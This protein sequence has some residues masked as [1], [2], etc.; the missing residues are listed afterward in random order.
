MGTDRKIFWAAGAAVLVLLVLLLLSGKVERELAPRP[1][2]AWV[3]IEVG[4]GELAEVGRVEIESG[5]PFTLHAVLEATSWRGETLYFTQAER[6]R[7]HGEEVPAESLRPWKSSAEIRIL[8]FTVEGFAPYLDVRRPEDFKRFR[9]R[10]SF[11]SEWP[12]AWSIPGHLEPSSESL[13]PRPMETGFPPFGTQRFHVRIE[14]Y[15]PESRIRPRHRFASWGAGD[16]PAQAGSFPTVSAYLPG[17][18]RVPSLVFGLTQ[19]EPRPGLAEERARLAEW[20]RQRIAFSRLTLLKQILDEAGVD[21][22]ELGWTG[23]DLEQGPS[24]GEGAVKPGDLLRVGEH[25]VILLRDRGVEDTLDYEDLCF[26][27]SKG[28]SLWPLGDVFVGE[29][30]VEWASLPEPREP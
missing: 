12:R 6:L 14:F 2:A 20:F 17:L 10:E 15:G 25:L 11:R 19:I 9:F 22:E 16:L 3:A 28:S 24:W 29:G 18:L 26:D 21:Y 30:L 23:V 8:W 4:G 1:K 5:T 27:F 7:I 13:R